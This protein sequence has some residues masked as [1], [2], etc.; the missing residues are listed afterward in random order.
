MNVSTRMRVHRS[1]VGIFS[2]NGWIDN[3]YM[4]LCLMIKVLTKQPLVL[5]CRRF[6]DG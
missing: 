1:N 6:I 5:V 3:F 2:Q 4:K